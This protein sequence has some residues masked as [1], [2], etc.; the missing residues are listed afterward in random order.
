[1][2]FCIIHFLR[3]GF[4]LIPV[5][6]VSCFSLFFFFWYFLFW[7]FFFVRYL[8]F[9][10]V[11]I[12]FVFLSICVFMLSFFFLPVVYFLVSFSCC[13]FL[14]PFLVSV[15]LSVVIYLFFHL[16]FLCGRRTYGLDALLVFHRPRSCPPACGLVATKIHL[17]LVAS[18]SQRGTGVPCSVPDFEGRPFYGRCTRLARSTVQHSLRMPSQLRVSDYATTRGWRRPRV[19]SERLARADTARAFL[20]PLD[21]SRIALTRLRAGRNGPFPIPSR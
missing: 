7:V 21:S 18:A 2:F 16:F 6:I 11:F 4:C 1:L 14:L 20:V 9:W 10:I 5:F 15:L 13:F 3:S 8:F 19:A 12:D 17:G